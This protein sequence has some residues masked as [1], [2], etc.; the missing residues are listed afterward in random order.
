ML[1]TI[2]RLRS[3]SA[4][5]LALA[6]A[7]A[8]APLAAAP[9]AAQPSDGALPPEI[10]FPA[11]TAQVMLVGTF[12][13][14]NPG[15]DAYKHRFGV[16]ILSPARQREVEDVVTRLAAFRPTK[17]AVEWSRER[18]VQLDSLYREYRAGRLQPRASEVFQLGFRLAARLG[19]ERVYAVN[20]ERH[21][22][23]MGSVE[24]HIPELE[25]ADSTDAWRARYRR[26]RAW[27][28]SMKATRTLAAHLRHLND[29]ATIRR[30]HGSY[31]TGFFTVGGDSSYVGPD[32]IAGWFDRNLRIFRNLQR[33][34]DRADERILVVYGAGHLATLRHFVES[35][36][37][38]RLVE[39]AELLA[40]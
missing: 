17:V 18:Q 24:P 31:L 19:H 6:A 27:D 35:S 34:T 23:L 10:A 15:L 7:V 8:T 22:A 36:P 3:S 39:A 33:I 40:P 26:W 2:G 9:L 25:H 5:A 20:V 21:E 11:P 32:F 16:D 30:D 12:H 13:F 14:D 29:P 38:Y 1:R 37:E 28:D 4:R